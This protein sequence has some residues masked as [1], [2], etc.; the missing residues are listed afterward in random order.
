MPGISVSKI[1]IPFNKGGGI[2][3]ASYWAT[4]QNSNVVW[5]AGGSERRFY[6]ISGNVSG[7]AVSR[8]FLIS[9]HEG[10]I[11]NS[12]LLTNIMIFVADKTNIG[13]LYFQVWRKDGVTYDRI[14]Q[15]DILSKVAILGTNYITL[16]TPI[17]VAE[18]DYMGIGV[19]SSG[20]TPS[21]IFYAELSPTSRSTYYVD[22][23]TPDATDYDWA[24]KTATSNLIAIRGYIQA[25]L[26]VGIG[27]SIMA[28]HPDHY[29]FIENVNDVYT[30]IG[31]TILAK[32]KE[33]SSVFS[34]QNMGI[35]GQT[36]T[37][38]KTRFEE[39]CCNLYPTYVLI[40]GGLNDIAG[41][42]ITE[43]TFLANYTTMLDL[44]TQN[45]IIPIVMSIAPWT[46][47]TEAQMQ[48]RDLWNTSLEALVATYPK[49]IWISLD[50]LGEFRVGGDV[51]NLWDIKAAYNAGDDVHINETGN[52]I[53]ASLVYEALKV[54][55]TKLTEVVG[56]ELVT[57]G[58]CEA[59]VPSPVK[60]GRYTA[61]QSAD[62]AHGGSNSVKITKNATGSFYYGPDVMTVGKR[63]RISMWIYIPSG[64]TLDYLFFGQAGADLFG[65]PTIIRTKDE[66]VHIEA[67]FIAKY[68]SCCIYDGSA[69]ALNDYYYLDD[70]SVKE[71]T[72]S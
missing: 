26:I 33:L 43:A 45:N 32:L 10:R 17:E 21:N 14:G 68:T 67:E 46:A 69:G 23:A 51:G 31:I 65:E 48:K 1:P 15:E 62:Q 42:S 27:D 40:N 25:P 5:S 22:D 13:N 63:Y 7:A 61:A 66:W 50:S 57:R 58:D 2:S 35:G 28:G 59:G 39:Y 47:G 12:G 53:I 52:T 44:C 4:L 6:P 70:I 49:A 54:N 72:Y 19:V 60:G 29:S 18:G 37:N 55:I 24:T 56:N 64:Q 34:Y 8:Y 41:G 36:S 3:W 38:I 16:T 71:I 11:R 30:D 9:A 20:G